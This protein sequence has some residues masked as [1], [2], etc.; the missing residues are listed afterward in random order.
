MTGHY[1]LQ[2][3]LV[4]AIGFLFGTAVASLIMP[5]N[6]LIWIGTGIIA[7]TVLLS[8]TNRNEM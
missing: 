3:T 1:V 6:A 5:E 8:A 7:A 2:G 4:L